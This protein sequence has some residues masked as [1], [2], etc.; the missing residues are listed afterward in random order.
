MIGIGPTPTH[1]ALL[2]ALFD[3]GFNPEL[4][5]RFQTL[6]EFEGRVRELS[7]PTPAQP[8]EDLSVIASRESGVLRETDRATLLAEVRLKA[9]VVHQALDKRIN[10]VSKKLS[11][12]LFSF[13]RDHRRP[14][15]PNPKEFGERIFDHSINVQVQN[16]PHQIGIFHLIACKGNECCVLRLT[17]EPSGAGA[18]NVETEI[19]M[20]YD[21][22]LGRPDVELIASEFERAVAVA[23]PKLRDLIQTRSP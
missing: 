4:Q 3:R 19:V 14:A 18:R 12:S 8:V 17:Y 10:E 15:D 1:V 11:G 23:I 7:S 5:N 9:A 20:R 22:K 13:I 6:E 21:A 2:N 16:H